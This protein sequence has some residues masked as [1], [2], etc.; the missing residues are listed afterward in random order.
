MLDPASFQ[1]QHLVHVLHQ[2]TAVRDHNHRNFSVQR[3]ERFAK[4]LFTGAVKVGIGL[5][6]HQQ[7]RV[8]VQRPCQSNTLALPR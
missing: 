4:R 2:S 7:L 3:L 5:I 8:S 1:N 6:Q